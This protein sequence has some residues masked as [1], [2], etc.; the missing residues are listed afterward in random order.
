MPISGAFKRSYLASRWPVKNHRRHVAI[1]LLLRAAVGAAH[2]GD[3]AAASFTPDPP[4][5]FT[6]GAIDRT[7][8]WEFSVSAPIRIT[9]IGVYDARTVGVGIDGLV[10]AHPVA[11][12]AADGELVASATVPAGTAAPL[13][14]TYRYTEVGAVTLTPGRNYIVAQFTPG[15]DWGSRTF[16]SIPDL[17]SNPPGQP[18]PTVTY[19]PGVTFV[20]SWIRIFQPMIAFP[21]IQSE[22]QGG[23][24]A[25][26]FRFETPPVGRT[27]DMNCDEA[28]DFDDITPFVAAVIGQSTYDAAYPDCRWL[29][30]DTDGD[31]DVDFDDIDGFVACIIA[32]VC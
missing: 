20:R 10:T 14:G 29:N 4:S 30:G 5:I 3:T 23:V 18:P 12:W 19:A 31:D 2:A 8:G 21:T 17:V 22:N 26:N 27:G 32:G 13:I 15:G 1:A 25:V 7:Y 11:I 24:G 16:D 6:T 9:R 28:V